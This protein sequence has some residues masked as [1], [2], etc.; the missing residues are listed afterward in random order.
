[1][2][3]LAIWPLTVDFRVCMRTE[4]E[5][6]IDRRILGAFALFS[7]GVRILS[8]VL[9]WDRKANKNNT[10]WRPIA[11]IGIVTWTFIT[12]CVYVI[13]RLNPTPSLPLLDLSLV[14][15]AASG[16]AAVHLARHQTRKRYFSW[17]S[18]L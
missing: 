2:N 4:R 13:V 18:R 8:T 17:A 10:A 14:G 15:G 5:E 9:A 11:V 6:F 7:G 3:A 16:L 12:P 1:M